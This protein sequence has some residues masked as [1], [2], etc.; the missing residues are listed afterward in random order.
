MTKLRFI[1]I[2]AIVLGALMIAG[3][4]LSAFGPERIVLSEA[5]L[6]ER[7]NR[8]LPRQFRGVTVERVMVSLADGGISLRV[9]THA[10]ALGKTFAATAFA[11]GVPRYDAERG[12]VF[13]DAE[14]VRLEDFGGGDLLKQLGSHI[15][16]RLGEG[17]EQNLPRIEGA[18]AGVIASGIK[19][20]LAA[21]PVYRFKDDLKGLALKATIKDITIVDDT[22][23]IGVSLIK[24][25]TAVG[26]WLFGL[27]LV[28]L[29]A[30]WSW[31]VPARATL[32]SAKTQ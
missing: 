23:A 27:G 21:R 16:G 9:E 30:I 13:F 8:E 4:A 2:A 10:T 12:E 3:A 5:Q 14:D 22:L 26:G 17:I 29:L 15:G 28:V 25:T 1:R 31:S 6:R 19:A 11:R 20:Y 24:L 18:A 7:I 32:S